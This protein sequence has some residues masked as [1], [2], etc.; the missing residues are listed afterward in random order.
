MTLLTALKKWV[1]AHRRKDRKITQALDHIHNSCD[2][3]FVTRETKDKFNIEVSKVF[4][5]I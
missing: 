1:D 3:G 4:A 2:E 5:V